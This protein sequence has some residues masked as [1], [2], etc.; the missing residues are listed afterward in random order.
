VVIVETA[1][2]ILVPLTETFH[3]GNLA[4]TLDL[5]VLVVAGSKLGV[6]NHTL[7]TLEYLRSAGLKVMACVLNHPWDERSAAGQTN[8]EALEGLVPE[9]LLVLPHAADS[10]APE[11]LAEFRTL[12][13]AVLAEM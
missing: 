11:S 13:S 9:R 3:Y 4:K 5:P 7:L 6:I 12:A 2:G 8:A 10:A 1:G